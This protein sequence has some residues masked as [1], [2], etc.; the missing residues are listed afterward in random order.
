MRK[1]L[2]GALTLAGLAGILP[3]VPQALAYFSGRV[4]LPAGNP[5]QYTITST[6]QLV[7]CTVNNTS[8]AITLQRQNGSPTSLTRNFF[9]CTNNWNDTVTLNWGIVS[10][11]GS[12]I[13]VSG[14]SGAMGAG[15]AACRPATLTVPA[16]TP[17]GNYHVVFRGTTPASAT[18][19]NYFYAEIQFYAKV[20]I[21]ANANGLGGGCP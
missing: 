15:T 6:G 10:D 1:L 5:A 11:G 17:T 20:K 13:T 18:D 16:G 7:R 2:A 19:A 14:D 4:D 9:H 21:Q 8:N 12:G 3:L